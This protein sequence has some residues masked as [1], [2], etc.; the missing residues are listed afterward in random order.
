MKLVLDDGKI[1][2]GESFG[3]PI[4]ILGEVV[5]NTGMSGYVETLTDPSY[6]GQIL[7]LT[8]PLVGNYG[9]PDG[10]FEHPE[11]QVQGLI[12]SHYSKGASHYTKHQSLM[13]W[14]KN[15]GVPAIS[16]I[17]TRSLTRYLREHG[18]IPGA[19][20]LEEHEKKEAAAW[21]GKKIENF[22]MRKVLEVAAPKSIVR[23]PGG[24]TNILV[25]DTGS[26][27]NIIRS[28]VKRGASVIRAP[29][30]QNWEAF[31]PEVDGIFLTNGPGDPMD[32]NSLIERVRKLLDGETPVFGICF[33]HQ[34]L[35][36][37]A[38]AKTQ[39]MKYGHRGVNQPVKDLVSGRC[40][41]TSQNHGYVVQSESLPKN[42]KPWFL[43]LNDGSNEG[44]RHV[45]KP[46]CS[47]QFHPE[48]T[49][50]PND[51]AFLFDEFL[52]TARAHKK[53]NVKKSQSFL[54]LPEVQLQ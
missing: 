3:A 14:L 54:Q 45:S 46:I 40:Y 25:I 21:T 28:L 34:M 47:V 48:A 13:D 51:T 38:G 30:N 8:Y 12:V 31:V 23:S 49:P 52:R 2:T 9:V 50:G 22:E 16:G 39:K 6:R 24:D 7:V 41:I 11:I 29:W 4:E 1:L 27:E 20:L 5:F 33:G 10:P 42:F 44:I 26:K 35:G 18:A 53:P 19:I 37:A 32:A 15:A 17:D 43:N 36:L